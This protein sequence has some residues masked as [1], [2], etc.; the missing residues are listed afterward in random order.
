M[1]DQENPY[2]AW[3]DSNQPKERPRITIE[4]VVA[5]FGMVVFSWFAFI[6][7]QVFLERLDLISRQPSQADYTQTPGLPEIWDELLFPPK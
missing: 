2:R 5:F 7:V 6:G 3:K 4:D 1:N